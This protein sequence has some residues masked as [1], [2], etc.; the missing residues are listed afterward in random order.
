M[1]V[2]LQLLLGVVKRNEFTG[3]GSA[4]NSFASLS[5]N[6]HQKLFTHRIGLGCI[7]R[8]NV[9]KEIL[10]NQQLDP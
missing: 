8:N 5:L 3:D 10:I 6:G 1:L 9:K 2:L 7:T 4:L